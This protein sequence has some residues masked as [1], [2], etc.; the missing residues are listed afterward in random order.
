MRC[1]FST[2]EE[3]F[4]D[5]SESG[6]HLCTGE[7]EGFGHYINECRMM[8]GVPVVINGFPMRELVDENSGFLIEPVSSE[9]RGMGFRYKITEVDLE[10]CIER[11][12][13]EP[14]KNLVNKGKNAR[15]RY[16]MDRIDFIKNL[17]D[18]VKSLTS[19]ISRLN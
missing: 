17:S 7:I 2:D 15:L 14:Y 13:S 8:G 4:S 16:E 6:I 3:Y 9:I 5:L 19:K 12:I 1:G 18:A 11:V 10:K